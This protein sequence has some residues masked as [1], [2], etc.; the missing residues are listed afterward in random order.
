MSKDITIVAVDTYAHEL[1][2]KAI[3]RTLQVLP[4]Q[5]VL[6]LSDKNIYPDGRWAKINPIDIKDYNTL[7]LKHLWPLVQTEHILVVQYDGMA[8]NADHWT[9][10]F[11]NYDY[12]GA[13]WPWPHHP[14]EYKV[15]NGGFSLRSRRLLN[16]LKDDRVAFKDELSANEDLYIGVYYKQFLQQQ[17]IKF[18]DIATANQFSHEHF[19]KLEPTFGFHGTFNVPYYLD[20]ATTENFI[21]LNPSW[22]SEGSMMMIAH[23]FIA[24][25][26]EL[27][28]LALKIAREKNLNTDQQ[29]RTL[30]QSAEFNLGLD[31][32]VAQHLIPLL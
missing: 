28:K 27:G 24:K 2:R 32:T 10:D 5:E 29:L 17:G 19:P 4:C 3:D 6:V 7:M 18:A 26:L 13:V 22:T 16:A 30:L 31:P 25:K 1:T 21:K 8:I 15:G 20:D 9:D 14:P 23:C 11:L 12:I